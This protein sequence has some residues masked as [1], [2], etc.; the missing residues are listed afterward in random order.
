[1]TR[2]VA[3]AAIDTEPVETLPRAP[4]PELVPAIPPSTPQRRAPVDFRQ[5][6]SDAFEALGG[7]DGFVKWVQASTVNK[8]IFYKD[9]MGK[10][11]PRAEPIVINNSNSMPVQFNVVFPNEKT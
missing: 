9:I 2:L 6:I 10:V 8:R 3:T 5:V 11:L 7:T 1:M 4:E